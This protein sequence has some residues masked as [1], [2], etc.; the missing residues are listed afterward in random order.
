MP[1]ERASA[2]LP[3]MLF[4]TVPNPNGPDGPPAQHKP[5]EFLQKLVTSGS[6]MV[7][8]GKRPPGRLVGSA[9]FCIVCVPGLV[10]QSLKVYNPTNDGCC[11]CCTGSPPQT[12]CTELSAGGNRADTGGIDNNN[13]DN[14]NNGDS[15]KFVDVLATTMSRFGLILDLIM[16]ANRI[17][18]PSGCY[19]CFTI[20]SM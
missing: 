20:A 14:N 4:D 8:F 10:I 7:K 19:C 2:A 9:R 16:M 18:S 12:G 11:N 3:V 6:T 1:P 5:V 15:N 13:I 17:D